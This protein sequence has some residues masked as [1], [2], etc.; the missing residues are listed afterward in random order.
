[1]LLGDL[2]PQGS[3]GGIVE[4]EETFTG[5]VKGAP[6]ERAFRHTMKV[7]A[8]VDRTPARPDRWLL[9]TSRLRR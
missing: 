6:V 3:G 1:M 2:A 8:L 9:T 5:R 7:L 4:A